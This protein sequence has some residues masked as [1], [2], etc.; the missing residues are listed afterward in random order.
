MPN[1]KC[2][3]SKFSH[4]IEFKMT[5]ISEPINVRQLTLQIKITCVQCFKPFIFKGPIGFSTTAAMVSPDGS[6]LRAPMDYPDDETE[7][8]TD[9]DETTDG[10]V[11]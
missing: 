4:K 11:H 10:V 7:E 5:N 9:P 1:K 3:H 2:V 8:Q 6:E